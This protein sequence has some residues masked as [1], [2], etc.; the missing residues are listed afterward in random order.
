MAFILILSAEKGTTK[1]LPSFSAGS[2]AWLR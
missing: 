1:G 2:R